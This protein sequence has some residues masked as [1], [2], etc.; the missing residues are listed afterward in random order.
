M[1]GVEESHCMC[2]ELFYKALHFGSKSCG[3]CLDFILQTEQC[4]LYSFLDMWMLDIGTGGQFSHGIKL[5]KVIMWC[6]V[7]YNKRNKRKI[8]FF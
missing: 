3:K 8:H 5:N 7:L 2:Q 4:L 6:S 1:H